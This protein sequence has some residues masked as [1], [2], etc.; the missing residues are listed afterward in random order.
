M[1]LDAVGAAGVEKPQE[2]AQLQEVVKPQE[3][4]QNETATVAE[5][6]DET[7]KTELQAQGD[8]RRLQ[9]ETA[10]NA[11]ETNAAAPVNAPAKDKPPP[12]APVPNTKEYWQ[13]EALKSAGIDPAK[14]D[15]SKGFPV[16]K[17]ANAP[18]R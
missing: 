17:L 14:W 11:V 5:V 10:F 7:P 3:K 9:T 18:R 6:A 1:G 13:A 8:Y 15:P 12:V 4:P 16:R 2:V